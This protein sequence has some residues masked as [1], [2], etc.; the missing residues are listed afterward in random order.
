MSKKYL[1]PNVANQSQQASATIAHPR[2]ISTL[3]S[4]LARDSKESN[5]NDKNISLHLKF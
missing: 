1:S 2:S 5:E 4:L 3:R